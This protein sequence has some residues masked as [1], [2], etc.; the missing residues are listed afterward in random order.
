MNEEA[1]NNGS[2]LFAN[3][4]AKCG[5]DAQQL[6]RTL[7]RLLVR[8]PQQDPPPEEADLSQQSHRVLRKAQELMKDKGDTFI[9]QDLLCVALLAD[10]QLED[11]MKEA[12]ITEAGLKKAVNDLRGGKHV[13][14]KTAEGGFEALAK[15]AIDLTALAEEGK[16]DPVR[17]CC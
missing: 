11:A 3:L 14:S 2:N 1:A 7:Q 5:G 4:I 6:N 9:S 12:A 10:K 16:I 15:Y 17:L 8:L 13:D